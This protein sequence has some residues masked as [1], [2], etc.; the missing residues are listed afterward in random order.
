MAT[1]QGHP[2]L[3]FLR[4][5][6]SPGRAEDSPDAQ[7]LARFVSGREEAAFAELVRRHG[8]MVLCYLEGFTQEEVARRLGCPR[9]TVTTRLT[10]ACERLRGRLARRGLS[11]PALAL[12]A[13][14]SD[15][16]KAGVPA[17]LMLAT[18][19]AA[20]LFAA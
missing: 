16:A 17:G 18:A 19:R 14:L 9:K 10:R 4:R 13:A 20:A 15:E 12:T 6:P 3:R 2:L 1:S 5:I 11:L 8:P 7:L